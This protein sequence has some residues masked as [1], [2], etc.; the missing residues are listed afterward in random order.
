MVLCGLKITIDQRIIKFTGI[1]LYE[2]LYV[3]GIEKKILI[4]NLKG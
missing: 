4:N 2:K 1:G 3:F